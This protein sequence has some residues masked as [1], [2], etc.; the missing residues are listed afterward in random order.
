MRQKTTVTTPAG[1]DAREVLARARD[2]MARADAAELER[3]RVHYLG[4]K[5]G[6]TAALKQ[7]GQL[8]A[9]ERRAAGQQLNRLRQKL[10]ALVR[11]R[12]AALDEQES[13]QRLAREQLD[14]SLPGRRRHPGSLHPVTTT[15]RSVREYFRALGF[16][17]ADGPEI[18]DDFHNF[19]CLLYTSDAA[20]E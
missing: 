16:A 1:L 19:T 9:A 18:E 11:A 14:V 7:L 5:G 2:E 6:V 4:K 13:E 15:M 3:L 20:D 10:E 8:P 17:E 12:R